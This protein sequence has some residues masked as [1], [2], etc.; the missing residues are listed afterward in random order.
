MAIQSGALL[1]TASASPTPSTSS[2]LEEGASPVT[3]SDEQLFVLSRDRNNQT[4]AARASAAS[5]VL[6]RAIEEG[7]TKAVAN[8][9]GDVARIVVGNRL[10]VELDESDAEAAGRSDLGSYA[11]ETSDKVRGALESEQARR[12]IANRVLSVS[13]V[14]FFGFIA[15]MLILL[16]GNVA[17]RAIRYIDRERSAIRP[18]Q[19][20][21]LEILPAAAARDG[22]RLS[23]HGGLWLVR[24]GLFYFWVLAALSLFASTR[25]LASRATTF[26]FSPA[27]DLL[28]QLLARLP[29]LLAVILTFVVLL[30]V[31]R[32]VTLY[33][34]AIERGEIDSG[35][36]RPETAR[37]SGTLLVAAISIGALLFV[38]PLFAGNADGSLPRL[39]LVLLGA[40]ALGATPY[41]G[42]CFLG[43]RAVY[44]NSWTRG[45]RIE[46]GGQKGRVEHLGLF[47]A[48][49]RTDDGSIVRVPHLMSLWHPTRIFPAEPVIGREGAEKTEKVS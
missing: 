30:F 33:C 3:L 10:L 20:G 42:S 9:K 47:D 49:L 11:R 7:D 1:A 14:V 4:A 23:I 18:V 41:L 27:L 16:S 19:V 31:V 37:T 17:R 6:E 26:L 22:I 34:R 13:S 8:V 40:V 15:W 25:P 24:F 12:T 32:F 43:I 28:G 39:G 48:T 44:E 38:T 46:Y 21:N 2:A 5:S 36:I 35:W 45:D 29:L